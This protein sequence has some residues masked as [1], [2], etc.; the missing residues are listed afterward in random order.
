MEHAW[1]IG[2]DEAE[3]FEALRHSF[4]SLMEATLPKEDAKKA[5]SYRLDHKIAHASLL[6]IA[7]FGQDE[8]AARAARITARAYR[9]SCARM[10]LDS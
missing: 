1:L 3:H 9:H 10:L 8:R 6:T 2:H 4:L 5:L 7:S